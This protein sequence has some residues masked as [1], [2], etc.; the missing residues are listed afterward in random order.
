MIQTDKDDLGHWGSGC[1]RNGE[2]GEGVVRLRNTDLYHVGIGRG[3][4]KSYAYAK[5]RET[6][7][8]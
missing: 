8:E 3:I 4:V 1:C 5:K 6:R 2:R 7:S